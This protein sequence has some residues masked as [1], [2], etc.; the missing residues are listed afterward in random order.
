MTDI[1]MIVCLQFLLLACGPSQ[2]LKSGSVLFGCVVCSDLWIY[3]IS[4]FFVV[5]LWY[6]DRGLWCFVR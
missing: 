1:A 6:G 2:Q 3:I 5:C 4:V